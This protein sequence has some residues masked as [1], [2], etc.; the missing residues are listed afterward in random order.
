MMHADGQGGFLRRWWLLWGILSLVAATAAVAQNDLAPV[1][2]VFPFH[3]EQ[4]SSD[5]LIATWQI[6]EDHY[7]YR[8]ALDFSLEDGGNEISQVLYPSGE[9]RKDE[10]FGEV[11]IY[12]DVLQVHIETTD[13]ISADAVLRAEYQGCN[14]PRELCYPPSTVAASLDSTATVTVGG[15]TGAADAQGG[16]GPG[17]QLTG[18]LSAGSLGAILGGFFI[19]GL[20]LAFTACIYP[21]IPILSGLIVGAGSG[22]GNLGTK[23]ALWLS[24]LY[25]QAVAITYAG[26]GALAGMTGRA[27]QAD[28]QG[29]VASGLFGGLFVL[30]ALAMFGLYDLQ[31]PA[32]LQGRLQSVAN[33][34]PGG[35]EVGVIAMGVLSTL[36]VGACSGPALIAALAFIG[37]TGEV[38]VGAA[39]LYVLALGMGAPLLLVGTAAG[40]WMPRSG[41]WMAAVKQGFGFVFLGVALWVASRFLPAAV[42]LT[43]WGLLLAGAALWLFWQVAPSGGGDSRGRRDGTR[44]R[45]ARAVSWGLAGLV[46]LGAAGQFFG[47]ATGASDPLRPWATVIGEDPALSRE[48]ALAE[49]ELVDGG[50]ERLAERI[51]AAAEQ[52]RKSVVEVTAQWCAY[53]SQLEQQTLPDSKV[54]AVLE[55]VQKLRVDVTSMTEADRELLENRGIYLPPAIMFFDA[56]GEEL[57]EQRVVGFKGPAEFAEQARAALNKSAQVGKGKGKAESDQ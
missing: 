5:R 22:K 1:K 12:R 50:G 28:L 42:E 54:R 24:F 27:I 10:F 49:W 34:L 55:G 46:G 39:A 51:A 43:A 6:K 29:P 44:S 47:A 4:V 26:A 31:M 40:R 23:R 11:E 57:R 8:H 56:N 38:A 3:L 41:P 9:K 16:G 13:D 2:E 37:N 25:V 20:A 53:C 14:E 48:Q 21:M 35:Q 33:R 32:S 19:A 18:L 30:L 45:W 52:D 36:I 15:A 7:L 17:G